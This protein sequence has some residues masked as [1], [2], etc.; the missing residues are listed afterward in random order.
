MRAFIRQG[1]AVLTVLILQ[2]AISVPS[3]KAQDTISQSPLS[4]A[5]ACQFSEADIG[6]WSNAGQ[7]RYEAM[8]TDGQG[9]II[10]AGS[11]SG[12][13]SFGG[14]DVISHGGI[15]IFIA[16]YSST[17]AHLWSRGFGGSRDDWAKAVAVD[18]RRK[19]HHHEF[20]Q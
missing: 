10:V 17:G 11:F 15:D 18:S 9:N 13:V 14:G 3:S 1:V 19:H 12:R 4:P 16:K 2:T 5:P 7:I 20:F 6:P 8:A